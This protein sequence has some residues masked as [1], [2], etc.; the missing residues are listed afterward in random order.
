MNRAWT[1]FVRK[2]G[3][4]LTFLNISNKLLRLSAGVHIRHAMHPAQKAAISTS[5]N[6]I[7]PTTACGIDFEGLYANERYKIP[8][9]DIPVLRKE[10]PSAKRYYEQLEVLKDIIAKD[11]LGDADSE[12]PIGSIVPPELIDQWVKF[13]GHA[14]GMPKG[15]KG[16]Y[17]KSLQDSAPIELARSSLRFIHPETED[18]G[19]LRGYSERGLLALSTLGDLESVERREPLIAVVALWLKMNLLVR[20]PDGSGELK[21]TLEW[22][23]RLRPGVDIGEDKVPTSNVLTARMRR[24]AK[25]LGEAHP[26]IVWWSE[27][28]AP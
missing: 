1:D 28:A 22:F 15:I 12:D 10:P 11:Q 5:P 4:T 9:L 20:H 13:L 6:N 25:A 19:K 24:T 23:I 3:G 17:G 7:S 26:N 2:V 21:S 16:L 14:P 8:G 27:F 18:I